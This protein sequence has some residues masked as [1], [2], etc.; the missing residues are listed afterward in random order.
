M[1]KVGEWSTE[2]KSLE[3][4][5]IRHDRRSVTG[6]RA[7]SA[8][9]RAFV[10]YRPDGPTRTPVRIA[11]YTPGAH[12]RAPTVVPVACTNTKASAES[13]RVLNIFSGSGEGGLKIPKVKLQ[14]CLQNK[15]TRCINVYV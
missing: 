15:T 10:G 5:G 1:E 6:V 7:V 12:E 8:K 9:P 13:R 11:R 4:S 2:Q 14:F 3:T